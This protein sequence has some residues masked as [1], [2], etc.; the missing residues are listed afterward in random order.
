[1]RK[2]EELVKVLDVFTQVEIIRTGDR[3]L[4]IGKV[5]DIKTHEFDEFFIYKIMPC[6]NSRETYLEIDVY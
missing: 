6:S 1:M 2:I 3:T 5:K 4:F